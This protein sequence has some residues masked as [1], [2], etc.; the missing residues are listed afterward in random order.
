MPD[1][2]EEPDPELPPGVADY[3]EIQVQEDYEE[4]AFKW[5]GPLPYTVSRAHKSRSL[6]KKVVT[7]FYYMNEVWKPT[8]EIRGK[9]VV[10]TEYLQYAYNDDIGPQEMNIVGDRYIDTTIQTV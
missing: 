7:K 8:G 9:S 5:D 1:F 2:T 4:E 10:G 3:E 6:D